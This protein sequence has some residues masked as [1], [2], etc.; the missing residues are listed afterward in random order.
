VCRLFGM[1]AGRTPVR[2][3]FWLLEAPDSLALQSRSNPDG[4]GIATYELDDST[5]LEKRPAAAYRDELFAREAKEEESRTFVAHVRYASAGRRTV[6]NTHPFEQDRLVFAHNGHIGG[7]DQL[8]ARLGEDRALVRG[9][10]DSE[11]LF[12]LIAK[13]AR[14]HDG[15]VEAGIVAAV[16]WV[17]ENLPL[18]AA[19]FVLSTPSDLWAFRYPEPHALLVLEREEGGW[20]GTRHLDAAS[21]GGTVRVRS[22]DLGARRSVIFASEPMDEDRGWREL[23]SGEL[24]HVDADLNTAARVVLDE[25]PAHQ[26]H[27]EDLDPAAA[28]AQRDLSPRAAAGMRSH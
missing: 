11:R 4:Y 18:F 20:S 3:T 17:A 25:P 22:S 26:L 21:A 27:L 2:A 12:A 23:A 24:A 28:A 16:G 5:H 9:D 10:T 15:D 13:E 19:N 1:T 8:E 14:R 6:E 7:L